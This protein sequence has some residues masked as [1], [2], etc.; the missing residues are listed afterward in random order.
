MGEK[1]K[2]NKIKGLGDRE[3]FKYEGKKCF[4]IERSVEI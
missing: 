1:G 2:R 4:F 3:L